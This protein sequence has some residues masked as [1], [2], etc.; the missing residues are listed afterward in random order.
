LLNI[1][2]DVPL[3]SHLTPPIFGYSIR[4]NVASRI[5]PDEVIE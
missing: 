1:H 5:G 4:Q 2:A 3:I